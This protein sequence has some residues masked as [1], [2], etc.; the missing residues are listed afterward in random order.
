MLF[1]QPYNI[2]T[3]VRIP[4]ISHTYCTNSQKR[5]GIKY[6]EKMVELLN[7]DLDIDI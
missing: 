3:E 5:Y 4:T 1:I 2:N 6:T 7:L